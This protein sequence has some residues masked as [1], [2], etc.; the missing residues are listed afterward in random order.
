MRIEY[1][2]AL[3]KAAD[4]AELYWIELPKNILK[5]NVSVTRPSTATATNIR[6]WLGSGDMAGRGATQRQN[7][8]KTEPKKFYWLRHRLHKHPPGRLCT[9]HFK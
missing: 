9:F 4:V 2:L 5:T 8:E 6:V 7:E 3:K 1:G